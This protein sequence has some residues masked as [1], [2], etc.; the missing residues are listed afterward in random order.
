MQLSGNTEKP[1][2]Q[3]VVE[4]NKKLDANRTTIMQSIVDQLS[5][6]ESQYMPMES[7]NL[8]Q[9][10]IQHE[11]EAPILSNETK[12]ELGTLA[13]IRLPEEKKQFERS[14]GKI[15]NILE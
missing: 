4:K 6:A 10:A 13:S 7:D 3:K 15:R 5:L 2:I 11:E 8:D 14:L 1:D 9:R 12:K